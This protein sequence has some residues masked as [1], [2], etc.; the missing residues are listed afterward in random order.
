MNNLLLK[1]YVCCHD[2]GVH[3][4]SQDAVPVYNHES[5][6]HIPDELTEFRIKD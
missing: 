1:D 6:E 2:K 5:I 4:W 3:T